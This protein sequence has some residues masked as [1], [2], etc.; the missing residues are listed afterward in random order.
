MG[1]RMDTEGFI[2]II[3]TTT[4]SDHSIC[5]KE[6][7]LYNTKYVGCK[8]NLDGEYASS[9]FFIMKPLGLHCINKVGFA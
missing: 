8:Y 2:I 9:Y 3:I 1:S 5:A 7:L 4:M 6:V